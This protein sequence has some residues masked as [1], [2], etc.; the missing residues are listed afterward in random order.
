[1]LCT[2]SHAQDCDSN[3]FSF[4]YSASA[5]VNYIK[6]V[7]TPDSLMMSLA[8]NEYYQHG[9][10]KFTA[11]GDV[12]FSYLYNSPFIANGYHSWTDLFFTDIAATAGSNYF[13]VGSVTKH[14]VFSDNTETPPARTAAVICKLDKY[15]KVIWSRFFASQN[16]DPLAF[17]NIIALGNGDVVVYL[18]TQRGLPYYGKVI[19]VSTNGDIK[20]MTILNTGDYR[21]GD[22][23]PSTKRSLIQ[24]KNGNIVIGEAVFKY[25]SLSADGAYHF[26][27][28][29][30]VNGAVNWET[31]YDYFSNPFKMQDVVSIVEL[32]DGGFSFQTSLNDPAS[33]I[34]RPL[35]IIT[36]SKGA[37]KKM[38]AIYP[39]DDPASHIVDAKP[40]GSSGNQAVLIGTSDN[41][42]ILLQVD[43]NGTLNWARKYGKSD[44]GMPPACFLKINNA[45]DI[46]L[47]DFS[48]NFHLLHTDPIGRLDCDSIGLT[49]IQET[50]PAFNESNIHTENVPPA[51][52]VLFSTGFF[53]VQNTDINPITRATVCQK[54]IPCCID[55]VDTTHINNVSLCEGNSYKLPDN[56]VVKDSGLYYVSYKTLKGCDSVSLYKISIAKNPAALS[57]GLDTCFTES[58]SVVL[59]ATDGYTSYKWNDLITQSP[60]YTAHQAGT[61][62]VSVSN[63]CGAKT[64]SIHVYEQCEFPVYMPNAFTPNGDHLNDLFR[65]PSVNLNRLIR[66][67]I[68]NRWGKVVF[69]TTKIND[70]WDGNLKSIPQQE[71]IYIYN[72]QMETITGKRINQKGTFTLVR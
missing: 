33:A 58:D 16:T 13:V 69:E 23:A 21:S 43:R 62:T 63:I 24:A 44:N 26:L 68:Y 3:Y 22:L 50:V 9:L 37:I 10:T 45:Y 49:M 12:V 11:Q 4:S 52:D 18:T 8:S 19:C 2:P 29:N 66:F 36:D 57:L 67:T 38:I 27:S 59:H 1:M 64:D 48:K 61:Y 35:N 55:V 32:P 14:G 40:D 47:S 39:S 53:V 71:G 34:Q 20:W 15:G 17:S 46:I 30:A 7:A 41:K 56:T 42:T 51:N 31:G 6:T 72:L 70:G 25:D 28:L 5:F 60:D 65:V 54:N